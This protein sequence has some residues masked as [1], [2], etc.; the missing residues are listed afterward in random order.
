M[1]K[2]HFAF[3]SR[4]VICTTHFIRIFF[5]ACV[6]LCASQEPIPGEDSLLASQ[7]EQD[8]GM[9][10]QQAAEGHTAP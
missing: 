5:L 6:G 8:E 10:M 9:S 7:E 1:L 4:G 2:A 3:F